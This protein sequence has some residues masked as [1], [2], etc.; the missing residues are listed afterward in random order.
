MPRESAVDHAMRG[1][2]R[3]RV[4]GR[5][6]GAESWAAT[7]ET[8][9][10]PSS[11]SASVAWWPEPSCFKP[12]SAA[13]RSIIGS[14]AAGCRRPSWCL[15]GRP[16]GAVGRGR[17]MAA[18]LTG[19]TGAALSHRSAGALWG[20]RATTSA[21]I[22][23]TVPRWRRPRRGIRLHQSARAVDERT[24]VRAIPVTT[25]PRTLL[26]LAA[27]LPRHAVARAVEGAEVL[28]LSDTPSLAKMADRYPGRRGV[29][30]IRAILATHSAGATL[31]RSELEE[32]FLALL[33]RAGLPRPAVNRSV[34]LR[35]R[36]IEADCVWTPER[37]IAELDGHA[38]T[39]QPPPSS[40]TAVAIEPFRP[41]GGG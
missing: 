14:C 10:S 38:F 24:T 36:W 28:R 19:G 5:A 41:T 37:V 40:A 2:R 6:R 15:C 30:A 11:P 9:R 4:E 1:E 25:V 23:V 12:A 13:G 27:V 21:L 33:E 16:F 17:W 34:Q 31:T 26:D 35:D 7:T 8:G 20:V 39:R 18:V 22:D 3:V 32:R 29:V